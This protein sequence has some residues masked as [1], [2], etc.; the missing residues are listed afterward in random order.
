MERGPETDRNPLSHFSLSHLKTLLP[1]YLQ[2]SWGGEAPR[3]LSALPPLRAIKCSQKPLCFALNVDSQVFI[4]LPVPS[5]F[6]SQ[7]LFTTLD[8]PT[9]PQ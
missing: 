6:E 9:P 8:K 7:V 2:C 4:Y 3:S 5:K 1:A